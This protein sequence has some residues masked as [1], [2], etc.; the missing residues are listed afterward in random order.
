MAHPDARVTPRGRALLVECVRDGWTVTKAGD[1]ARIGRQ[2]GSKWVGRHRRVG[3]AELLDRRGAVHRQVRAH[4]AGPVEIDLHNPCRPPWATWKKRPIS[5]TRL[6][7]LTGKNGR[8]LSRLVGRVAPPYR[9]GSAW[10]SPHHRRHASR[11]VEV[12]VV[13]HSQGT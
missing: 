7:H 3:E 11:R 1:A 6:L 9:S 2:T 13:G 12:E 4:P 8:L 5:R 10:G